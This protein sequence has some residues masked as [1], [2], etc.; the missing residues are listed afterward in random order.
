MRSQR[1]YR[2]Y[3]EAYKGLCRDYFF[4]GD[5]GTTMRSYAGTTLLRV[6]HG[7]VGRII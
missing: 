1:R 3:R 5:V 2:N 6:L 7:Q 4:S